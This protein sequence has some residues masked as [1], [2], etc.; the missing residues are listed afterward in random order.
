MKSSLIVTLFSLTFE[1][2]SSGGLTWSSKAW[3]GGTPPGEGPWGIPPESGRSTLILVHGDVSIILVLL[4]TE[5]LFLLGEFS[6]VGPLEPLWPGGMVLI[7]CGSLNYN[8]K[9]T[10]STSSF[11]DRVGE[12]G[13]SSRSCLHLRGW[14]CVWYGLPLLHAHPHTTVTSFWPKKEKISVDSGGSECWNFPFQQTQPNGIF[15]GKN[16][17]PIT[18]IPKYCKRLGMTE[19]LIQLSLFGSKILSIYFLHAFTYFCSKYITFVTVF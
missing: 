2:S 15:Q 9:A 16:T 1:F 8:N 4:L 17:Q 13:K 18:I 11:F 19:L 5:G 6:G 7:D 14:S 12:G 3:I 10:G